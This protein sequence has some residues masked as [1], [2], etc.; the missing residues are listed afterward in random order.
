MNRY[1]NSWCFGFFGSKYFFSLLATS[2]DDW[3]GISVAAAAEVD[4]DI[5]DSCGIDDNEEE[6]EDDDEEDDEGENEDG[7][8]CTAVAGTANGIP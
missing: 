5:N 6:D 1:R 7:S 2:F 4:S 8:R 3:R